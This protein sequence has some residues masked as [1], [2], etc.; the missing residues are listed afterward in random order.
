M[1]E[2]KG[3]LWTW[4]AQGTPI[5]ITTNGFVKNDGTAVMGRGCAKE[6]VMRFPRLRYELGEHL[7]TAGNELVWWPSYNLYTFPVKYNWWEKAA[8]ELIVGSTRALQTHPTMHE[9]VVVPRPGCGNGQL[10]W[11]GFVKPV[12]AEILD[13]RF[14]VVTQ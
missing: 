14:L 12:L 13:D 5:C 3:N 7:R 8:I 10:D 1:L 9:M 4:H 11:E 2:G 6:A